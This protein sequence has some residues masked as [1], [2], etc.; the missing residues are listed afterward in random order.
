MNNMEFNNGSDGLNNWFEPEIPKKKS[1]IIKV[2]GLGGGG[3]NAVNHMF[4]QG[5]VGVDF[6]IANTDQQALDASPVLNKI[7][8]GKN[9]TRGLGAGSI[10]EKG[11]MAAEESLDE[12]IERLGTET[13]MLFVTAG[14]GGGT[15][16]GAA[17]VIAAKAKEL[18]ILTVAIVTT[19]FNFE[20]PVRKA[21]AEKGLEEIKNAVD[22]YLVISNGKLIEQFRDMSVDMAF[23]MAD[24]VLTIAAKGIAEIITLAGTMNVD[25]ADIKTAMSDSGVAIM[26]NG[27][28][29]GEGRAMKAAQMAIN[30]PLLNATQIKGAANILLNITCGSSGALLSEIDEINNFFQLQ[31]GGEATL[32]WG[33]CIDE[34]LGKNISVTIIATGFSAKPSEQVA[35]NGD[36]GAKPLAAI[37]QEPV[38]LFMMEDEKLFDQNPIIDK[39]HSSRANQLKLSVDELEEKIKSKEGIDYLMSRPAYERHGI[40]LMKI[41]R[42]NET[43]LSQISLFSKSDDDKPEINRHNSFL[44]GNVD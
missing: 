25:F 32:K 10:A 19:P 44:D 27:I 9:L 11:K 28:A 12:V 13:Q 36:E 15:G 31:A 24:D 4:R 34:K 42:S 2:I 35:I 23:K 37:Q 41:E 3:G 8:L 18:G 38:T 16:T 29:E 43:K 6:F 14:L 33:Y 21:Q 26:G 20:G 39:L 7:Q 17:P 30:S 22:A 1:S 40:N 5:I